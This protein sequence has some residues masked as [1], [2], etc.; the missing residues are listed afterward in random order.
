M[1]PVGFDHADNPEHQVPVA[2]SSDR[3]KAFSAANAVGQLVDF[4]VSPDGKSAQIVLDLPDRKAAEKAEQNVVEVSPIIH[5]A[6]RDGRGNSYRDIIGRMDLVVHPVDNSQSKFRPVREGVAMALRMALG[7]GKTEVY[8]MADADDSRDDDEE[9]NDSNPIEMADDDDGETAAD[10]NPDM[11][12]VDDTTA[13]G[14][15]QLEAIIAHLETLG[16]SLPAD[17]DASNF[18]DRLLTAL[19]TVES[20]KA[21]QDAEDAKSEPDD[22]S[23]DEELTVA[24]PQFA[25]MS[26]Y[27]T[28]QHR[29]ELQQRLD[30]LLESG[31]C[32]PDQHKKRKDQ[33]NA[34]KLSLGRDGQLSKSPLEQWIEDRETL[35]QGACWE[36][37]Q[38]LSLLT[39]TDPPRDLVRRPGEMD[40]AEIDSAAAL[41]HGVR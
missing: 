14:G 41:F 24:D 18:Q 8:R 6:W 26:L 2:F 7:S 16:V 35:P 19:K 34:V 36:P 27:A 4:K 21:R 31:R 23:A 11:P 13:A 39:V 40:A 5:P 22:E 33:L 30:A 10:T 37:S 15:E 29:K 38:R 1:V 17:T 20:M 32:T 25:A 12:N 28:N 9:R 3:K